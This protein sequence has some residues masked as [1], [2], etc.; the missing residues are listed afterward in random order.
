MV[1]VATQIAR[2][3]RMP[4]HPFAVVHGGG[5]EAP[6]EPAR[7]LGTRPVLRLL[8]ACLRHR[9]PGPSGLPPSSASRLDRRASLVCMHLRR[10]DVKGVAFGATVGGTFRQPNVRS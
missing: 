6:G 10:N 8:R 9:L 7:S 4:E 5:P 3:P 1:E 2:S